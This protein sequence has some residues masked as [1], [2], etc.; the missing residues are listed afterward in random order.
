MR[1]AGFE[2]KKLFL[3]LPILIALLLFTVFDL[4][5]IAGTLR[6]LSWIE[7]DEDWKRVY[8]EQYEKYSGEITLDKINALL[9]VYRPL[10]EATHDLTA[11]T[12]GGVE[13][14]LTGNLYSDRNL[15]E[16]YYVD[17][18]ERFYTYRNSALEVVRAASENVELY[19][20]LGNKYEARKNAAIARL[21]SGRQI[22]DFYFTEGWKLYLNYDFSTVLIFLLV[23]YALSR[24]FACDSQ[25]RMTQLILTSAGGGIP[26][27]LAKITAATAYI[28]AVSVWFSA[29]DFAGFALMSNLTDAGNMP[30][31]AVSGFKEASVELTLFAYSAAGALT[32]A[33]GFWALGMVFL[34]LSEVGRHALAPFALGAGVFLLCT[35]AGARWG[36][37][38]RALFKVLNPY[39]LLVNRLLFGRTEFVKPLDIPVLTWQ[40]GLVFTFLLGVCAAVLALL[41]GGKNKLQKGA[42][43]R[44]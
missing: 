26:S 5:K 18:M 31:Y 15:L 40:A 22:T 41:F 29:V 3:R 20:S 30:V 7:A 28:F 36:Y 42:M 11:T 16:R 34:L 39:S 13:G 14:T 44:K 23:L 6:D 32:R 43:T 37:S 12:H 33:L 10:E 2:M 35:L 27:V 19:E 24:S 17:P 4:F 38:S 25:C 21:Y 9:K 8:W 1:L